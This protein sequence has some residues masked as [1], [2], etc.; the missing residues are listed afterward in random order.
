MLV[1]QGLADGMLSGRTAHDP[2]VLR[3]LLQVL[4]HDDYGKHHQ[5]Y[6]MYIMIM[7]N[8]AYFMADC[9]VNVEMN[10][11]Q[12]AKLAELAAET[13]LSLGC[14][15]RVGMLSFSN[16]GSV[17]H[18][19]TR[20]VAEATRIL[21]ESRPDLTVEG[22]MQA[23]TAVN[24]A[25]MKQY[26][27]SKLEEPANVLVFPTMQAGNISYKLLRELGGG[28][29][30]GPILLGLPYQAHVLQTGASVDDVVHMAAIAAAR[31]A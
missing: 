18:A 24:Q 23:D 11:E 20:K 21:H 3:P 12:L 31:E 27:F 26:P 9:T 19:E 10:A 4:G 30:I 29:A 2:A 13:A 5:V 8:G 28:T 25:I 7:E 6:G 22:E 15:A 1:R 16:F 17:D 14:E